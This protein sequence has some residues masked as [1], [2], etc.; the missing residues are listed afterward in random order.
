MENNAYK[1]PE[2]KQV[3]NRDDER[4]KI[5]KTIPEEMMRDLL[6]AGAAAALSNTTQTNDSTPA[7]ESSDVKVVEIRGSGE[8]KLT[9]GMTEAEP[10]KVE[11]V[12]PP[13]D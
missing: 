5:D 3:I 4:V 6:G 2:S 8:N 10:I 9:E 12:R 1:A 11:I 7:G 13:S